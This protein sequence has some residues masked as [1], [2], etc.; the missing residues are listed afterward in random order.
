MKILETF[1]LFDSELPGTTGIYRI[2]N[3]ISGKQYIGSARAQSEWPSKQGFR[4]R[5]NQ[6]SRGHR[7]MLLQ[8]SHHSKHLQSSYNYYVIEKGCNPN[9]V[10]QIQILEYVEPD[11]CIEVED[12]YL[13]LY[14]PE[15]NGTL[16]AAFGGGGK[17]SQE[18]IEKHRAKVK[19]Q[20]RSPETC[21]RISIALK[22]LT[23]S[24]ETC[25]KISEAKKGYKAS[26][27][28]RRKQ[29]EAHKNRPPA[30]P[31]TRK[32]LSESQ[33]IDIQGQTFNRLTAVH[34]IGVNPDYKMVWAC[35]CSCGN[36]ELVPVTGKSLR[37]GHTKSC[38]CLN[39]EKR[40]QRM[41]KHGKCET[42]E[43]RAWLDIRARCHNPNYKFYENSDGQEIKVCDRWLESF[44]NFLEDMGERPTVHHTVYKKNP[45]GDYTPDNCVWLAPLER[46]NKRKNNVHLEFNGET[47]TISE[48]AR[49]YDIDYRKFY[50][51]VVINKWEIDKTVEFYSNNG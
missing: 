4:C 39:T 17:R 12:Y 36:P 43:Y 1:T 48:W 2:Y 5:F 15:Y 30:S 47:K 38:G 28:T 19:G 32:N 25:R 31:E 45:K 51:K 41:T 8:N 24:P 7:A 27:E 46:N 10:F 16:D 14:K 13:K 26:E 35:R 9:D 33:I 21:K 29:S 22:G 44:E 6:G 42:T 23:R 18:T 50:R 20:K 34:R 40:K 37:S 3:K 49:Y 11:R